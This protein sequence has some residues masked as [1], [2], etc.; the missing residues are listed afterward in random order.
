VSHFFCHG[1]RAVA[2]LAMAAVPMF[3]ITTGHKAW[4][5][6]PFAE[7][8]Q[9]AP[10]RQR[11]RMQSLPPAN[12]GGSVPSQ[13]SL[14]DARSTFR[15]RY[16][17]PTSRVRTST[18]ALMLAEALLKEAAG[19]NHA[20]VKWVIGQSVRVAT[21]EFDF[22]ALSVEYRALAEIPLRALDPGRASELATAAGA[23]ATRAEVDRRFDVAVSAQGLAIRAWQRAG[24]IQAARL[25]SQ[26][27]DALE[28]AG[29]SATSP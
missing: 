21:A 10:R 2:L 15:K 6:P 17:D 13:R 8:E 11:P 19:E 14:V 4:S 25:A 26:R 3:G 22:D 9:A 12:R 1:R 29:R 28:S 23:V 20:A 18:A 7:D 16:G 24:D 27:R 5:G